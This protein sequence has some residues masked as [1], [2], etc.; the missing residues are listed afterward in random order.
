M[1]YTDVDKLAVNTIRLLS[2]SSRPRNQF[3]PPTPAQRLLRHLQASQLYYKVLI[4][5]QQ[6]DAVFHANAGHPGAP[7]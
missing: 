1:G 5:L 6:A 4:K 3:R 2:V 7:M